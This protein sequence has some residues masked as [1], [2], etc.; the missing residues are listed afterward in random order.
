MNHHDKSREELINELQALR[1]AYDILKASR[2]KDKMDR[3]RESKEREAKNHYREVEEELIAANNALREREKEIQNNYAI[4]NSVFESPEN[5]IIFSLDTN[6]CYLSFTDYH[7]QTMK[8]IWGVDIK[9]GLNMLDFIHNPADCEKAKK[10]FDRVLKGENLRFQEEYGDPAL[11]RAYYENIYNP[12]FDSNKNITG[13]A[14]FV[15]DITERKLAEEALRQS[16]EKFRALYANMSEG[17]AMHTLVYNDQGVPEDYLIIEVNPAF[18]LQLGISRE[19]VVHKTSR[20]AYRVDAPPYFEIFSRVALTGKPEVFETW[21]APLDKYFSISVYCP[22]I[23]SFATIFENITERKAT[24]EALEQSKVQLELA[25][26]SAGAGIWD[27]D[28]ENGQLNWSKELFLLFGLDPDQDKATFDTWTRIIHPDDR[29]TASTNIEH[30]IREKTRLS[31]VYRVIYPDG[32]VHWIHA[33]GDT[34]Y[35]QWGKPIRMAGICTDITGDK[36]AEQALK[37]SEAEL[38]ELNATKDKFFSIIAHDLK[39]P[40]N[41]ILGFSDMLKR[42]A[43]ELD[44]DSIV[45]SAGIINS[46]A[47]HAFNLLENLLEWARMQQGKILF[48]PKTFLLNGLV[49]AEID[50]QKNIADQKAI[51]LINDIHKHIILSAD[52]NMIRTIIRNLISNAIKFTPKNGKVT[53]EAKSDNGQLLISV[54]DTGIGMK[55]EIIEKLFKIETSFTSRGTENEKGSGL[56]LLLCKEFVEKHEGTI[57]VE[58]EPGKGSM[59]QFSIPNI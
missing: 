37:K 3:D 26:Q 29:E 32:K 4:L 39:S 2:E 23:G 14:V 10:N 51:A 44:I 33:L 30:A 31:N 28:M 12:I 59:F 55:K 54:S 38:R 27:W 25:L 45:Q 58:S 36:K 46:S 43:R 20:E 57:L 5:I 42:E 56:G 7:R 11:H 35:N 34:T 53:V 17:S 24:Q 16:E 47:K 15:I 19:E 48:E 8:K 18:E 21:F 6:Y 49:N 52:E 1:E 50:L 41:G 22:Y 9:T 13:L 40:F